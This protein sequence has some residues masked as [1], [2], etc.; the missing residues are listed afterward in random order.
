MT[1]RIGR[2]SLL[3]TVGATAGGFALAGCLFEDDQGAF[4]TPSQVRTPQSCSSYT[5]LTQDDVNGGETLETG[6][7]RIDSILTVDSGTLTLEKGVVIEFARGAGL[8]FVDDASTTTPRLVAD[9]TPDRPV[10]L[11]GRTQAKG[12]WRGLRFNEGTG[13]SPN[14]LS[15][16]VIE[17][18]GGSR[19]HGGDVSK[20]AVF[21]QNSTI[22]LSGTTFRNN[23]SWG[24][25]MSKRDAALDATDSTFVHNDAPA[26]VHAGLVGGFGQ[27]NKVGTHD[28]DERI[29]IAGG[30]GTSDT[31]SSDQT[32]VTQGVPYYATLNLELTS[33][34][35]VESGT[36]VEFRRDKGLDVNGGALTVAGTSSDNVTFRGDQSGRGAWGGIRFRN[37]TAADNVVEHGYIQGGG[38]ELWHGADFSAAGV[39]VQGSDVEVTIRDTVFINNAVSGLTASG[40]EYD[41]TV[42]GCKFGANE[43]PI[44]MD[45]DLISGIDGTNTFD[46]N[47]EAYV[48]VGN[49][50]TSTDV[51][52][53]ATWSALDVPYQC[54]WHLHIKDGLE[55]EPGTT[56]E[57]Q[58]GKQFMLH[59]GSLVAD[60]ANGDQITVTRA[61]SSG[62]WGGIGIETE[63][64]DNRLKNA[65][66]EYGGGNLH[67]G[68]TDTNA[69]IVVG[70]WGDDI[71]PELELEDV[72]LAD[73][74]KHG[75]Y[76]YKA[77][78]Q[79]ASVTFRNNDGYPVWDGA[80]DS[81]ANSC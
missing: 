21:V 59:G 19:W 39:F 75:L 64:T 31:I 34:L 66:V 4:E 33:H 69:N 50:G 81:G 29:Q 17:H 43:L 62:H 79:C 80:S 76:E 63:D 11:R 27:N 48:L 26:R 65:V 60:A 6:C 14:E 7:Y 78:L 15:N 45:A 38:G 13:N 47:D 8:S 35:T 32:W 22:D 70:S 36:V 2:R 5:T 56:V 67:T 37:T 55:L 18:A 42:E 23:A 12:H 28:D 41:I 44:R 30:S 49:H 77:N 61:G 25:S 53:A 9:G 16:V 74:N 58:D 68:D 46:G 40:S 10:F 71:R 54:R 52:R 24:L 51:K 20:A 72:E 57:M 3:R 73:S 1:D